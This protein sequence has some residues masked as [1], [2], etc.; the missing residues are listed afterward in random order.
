MASQMTT[1]EDEIKH[2]TKESVLYFISQH[3]KNSTI[4]RSDFVKCILSDANR[5]TQNEVIKQTK[6]TL[7]KVYGL[8]LI[9]LNE[10][11]K[12]YMLVND[13]EYNYNIPLNWPENEKNQQMLLLPILTVIFM[14]G[15]TI[16]EMELWSFLKKLHII[17]DTS[18]VHEKFGNIDRILKKDFINQR[19]LVYEPIK[20]VNRQDNEE[21]I[22]E[23]RWGKRAEHEVSKEKILQHVSEIFE[24]EITHFADQYAQINKEN[25]SLHG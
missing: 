20:N 8:E 12:Y 13:L 16:S 10:N 5:R 9:E 6:D 21:Y 1:D 3:A 11:V 25:S 7:K 19:Y 18:H 23:F 17:S 2:L 15:G 24:C 14:N 4:K 22:Y